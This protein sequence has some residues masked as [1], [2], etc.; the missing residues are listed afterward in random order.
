MKV[1]KTW[2]YGLTTWVQ[3][4]GFGLEGFG[5]MRSMLVGSEELDRLSLRVRGDL[6]EIS[7]T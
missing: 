3:A 2:R 6:E 4:S 5:F 7:A 1:E